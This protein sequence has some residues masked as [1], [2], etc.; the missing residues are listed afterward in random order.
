[1]VDVIRVRTAA[2]GSRFFGPLGAL[3]RPTLEDLRCFIELQ[4]DRMFDLAST[5]VLSPHRRRI[6]APRRS[7]EG[8]L[9]DEVLPSALSLLI[10]LT[11]SSPTM[12]FYSTLLLGT[13][14]A[15]AISLPAVEHLISRAVASST[16]IVTVKNGTYEGV[17]LSG[18][19]QDLYLGIPFA[20]PPAGSLVSRCRS[21]PSRLRSAH[22]PERSQR[23]EQPVSL[24]T[25]WAGV[26]KSTTFGPSCLQSEDCLTINVVKPAGECSV[27]DMPVL[28]WIFGGGF[29]GGSAADPAFNGSYIVQRSVEL[30][31]PIIFVSI[32]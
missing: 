3:L 7:A 32:K 15:G 12:L 2:Q 27:R 19:Q 17:H 21:S 14:L 16:P 22:P 10:F 4:N 23:F 26:K 31:T 29:A 9:E 24:T 13:T 11:L 25:T 20:Q 5:E 28:F 1:M 6:V 30:G 8:G 18:L